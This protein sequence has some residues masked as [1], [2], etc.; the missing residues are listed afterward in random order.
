[1][2][3][4]LEVFT[5][6]TPSSDTVIVY[7]TTVTLYGD[8]QFS[9]REWVG[10]KSWWEDGEKWDQEMKNQREEVRGH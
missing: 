2:S 7:E 4:V 3:K 9:E 8:D 10:R 1:M 6:G 5:E